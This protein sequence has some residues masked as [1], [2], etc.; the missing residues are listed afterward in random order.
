MVREG[1]LAVGAFHSSPAVHTLDVGSISPPVLEQDDPLSRVQP[2][3]DLLPKETR[4]R[5]AALLPHI[6]DCDTGK[7]PRIHSGRQRDQMRLPCER[8]LVRLERGGWQRSQVVQT[9][10]LNR[11]FNRT[12]KSI[13][14][15][16]ATTVIDTKQ[17]PLYDVY[18]RL[19]SNGTKPPLAKL[20]LARKL[21]AIALV[22][23]K[24]KEKYNPAYETEK[25]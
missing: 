12:L 5:P 22:L 13:F 19:L 2:L 1:H 8:I 3:R 16:A 21:A 25:E 15:G 4:Y 23:F 14:K 18:Q 20:T 11:D 17:Q 7:L 6:H 9:R 10:G 24:K